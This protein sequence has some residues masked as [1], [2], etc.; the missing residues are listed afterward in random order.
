MI[1]QLPDSFL[2][3]A[4]VLW[5]GLLVFAAMLVSSAQ[6]AARQL[7]DEATAAAAKARLREIHGEGEAAR[8]DRGVDQVLRLWREE[9]GGAEAFARLVEAEFVPSGEALDRTFERFEFAFERICG[10]MTSLVRDL[11]RGADLDLGPLLPLD[12]RLAGYNPAAH[13][14]DDLFANQIAFVALLNFPLSTLEQRLAEGEAWSRRQWAEARLVEGFATRIPAAASQV[15]SAA[16][17]AADSY[18]NGYNFHMHHLL[19]EDGRR[20]FPSGLRLITHWG[21]RDELKARYADPDGLEKQRLIQTVF[22]RIVRQEVPAAV[23]DNPGL[24]WKPISN[25][26]AP[27]AVEGATAIGDAAEASNEREAD[28]R[29]RHW[30]EIFRAQRLADLYNPDNPTFV[31]RRFNLSRQIP[32]QRVEEVFGQVL[33]SPLGQRAGELVARR[34]GRELEPFDIWYAGFK[35]RGSH[36]ETALDRLT[37]ERYPTSADF[38]ADLPRILQDLGFRPERARFVAERVVVEPSRGAGHAFG[39]GRR[40]DK[41]HLRTR[42]GDGGMDYKGFNIAIHEF[43]H[44]VEQVF[45]MST[46]D[47]TLL[48]GVPNTAFTEAMAFVFQNRDL[49]LLGLDAGDAEAEHLNALATFW[50]TREIAGVALVDMKVWRWLYEHPDAEP[51]DLRAAVVA[52]AREVWNRYFADVFG[53]RDETLLAVYSHMVDGAMYTPDYPLGHLIAFQIERYFATFEGS[54][55]DEFERICQLGALTPDLWMRRAVGATLSA[56]P[57]LA[58]TAEALDA[59]EVR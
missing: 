44:N 35:P 14:T 3:P 45:S 6:S 50:N 12:H 41:A 54:F 34:L 5:L 39:A 51:V 40:D 27:T 28:E 31:D 1:Q 19:T 16:M 56:Q 2:T 42:V 57:L 7:P 36:D 55:G 38:A 59:L 22:D 30:L 48:E 37:R 13:L 49:E 24:D 21:V 11:R 9:D 8:I 17:A 32:E 4:G 33:G 43:G 26:V 58:A 15:I 52:I 10:Y 47:H 53:S 29:Y 18:I 23:I 25:A 20:P 46:I